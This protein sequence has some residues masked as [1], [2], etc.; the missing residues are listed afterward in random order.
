M[1]EER[2]RN[3]MG[4]AGK[5]GVFYSFGGLNFTPNVLIY[6]NGKM[7]VMDEFDEYDRLYY[8]GSSPVGLNEGSIY[9]SFSELGSIFDSRGSAFDN[10]SGDIDN[11][12]HLSYEGYNDWRV[13]SAW[14]LRMLRGKYGTYDEYPRRNGCTFHYNNGQTQT[15]VKSICVKIQVSNK[16]DWNVT[17]YCIL[18]CPDDLDIYADNN[19]TGWSYYTINPRDSIKKEH[20]VQVNINQLDDLINQGCLLLPCEGSYYSSNIWDLNTVMQRSSSTQQSSTSRYN[21][22]MSI[23]VSYFVGYNN[24][25]YKMPVIL[26]RNA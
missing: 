26:C 23:S 22:S 24:K 2:R 6:K 14:E 18:A 3:L 15:S 12:N 13:P 5:R 8:N 25:D 20:F 11:A 4:A 10:N 1:S 16:K 21:L 7:Q 19:I 9:F 17:K